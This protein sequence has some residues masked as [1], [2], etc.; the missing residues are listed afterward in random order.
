M[1]IAAISGSSTLGFMPRCRFNR[2]LM[3]LAI[4]E[5]LHSPIERLKQQALLDWPGGRLHVY[6]GASAGKF[7]HCLVDT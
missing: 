2:H 3:H 7:G 6:G 1:S 4:F 5:V